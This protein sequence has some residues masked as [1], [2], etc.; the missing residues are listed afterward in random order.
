[1]FKNS[2]YSLLNWIGKHAEYNTLLLKGII[3]CVT[4]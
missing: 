3:K 1:M 4:V 2:G